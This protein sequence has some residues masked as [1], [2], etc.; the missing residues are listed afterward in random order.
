ME[1]RIALIA[2]SRVKG[3][4]NALKKH[5]VETVDSIAALFERKGIVF[6]DQVQSKAVSFRGWKRIEDDLKKLD[7]INA[8]VVTIRDKEY[9]PLLR[10][11]SD[12]PIVLY[13]KGP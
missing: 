8:G 10:N 9:P 2:L 11:I 1:E 6:D 4:N 5:V 3:I 13:K 7:D 12:P